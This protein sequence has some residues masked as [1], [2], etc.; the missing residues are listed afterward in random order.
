MTE[1]E[2][3]TRRFDLKQIPTFLIH[4]RKGVEQLAVEGKPA[5]QVPML[6][7]SIILLLRTL[8]SGF[9]QARA[10]A[11]GQAALPTDWQYWTPDMQNNYMQAI[12]ATQGVV[13]VYIIPVVMGMAKLWLGWLVLGGL[14]HLISTLFGGRGSM[15]SVLNLTA[16]AGL[17]FGLRDLLRVVYMLITKHPIFNPG[18]S[19]FSGIIFLSKILAGVDV[20][21]IWF[22]ILLVMGLRVT[23][24]LTAWKATIGVVIVLLLLLLAKSG[25]ETLSTS[26]G[27]MMIT[28]PFF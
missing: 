6:V 14:L 7:L 4:P 9:L 24:N 26:L 17:T 19:G 16:W 18:L 15:S 1:S 25:L 20:F 28:R 5:W 27:G 23:D 13:F 21:L 22:A 3:R 2:S 10:S 8:V 12:Q 11:L